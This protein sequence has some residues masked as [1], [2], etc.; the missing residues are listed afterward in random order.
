M[1]SIEKNLAAFNE[2]GVRPVAISVDSPEDNRWF[3]QQTGYTFPILS[4]SDLEAIRRF[5]LVH[6]GA[7]ENGRDIARPGEFLI[8]ST[9]VVRW[10]SLTENYMVRARVEE[11][12]A[13]ARDLK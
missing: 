5:E 3:V 8:D 13:A 7:G 12:L 10:V 4:D 2:A 9:A 1:R 6:A 11:M